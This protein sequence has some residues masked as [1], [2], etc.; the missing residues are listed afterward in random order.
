MA[1]NFRMTRRRKKHNLYL[2]LSGDF[3]GMS[4]MELIQVL[5]ENA[6]TSKKIY[7][8]T[9]GLCR[10][11]PFGQDV[12]LK[13]FAISAASSKKL[14]FKGDSGQK[15]APRGTCCIKDH[16]MPQTQN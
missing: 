2:K 16:K 15:I 14:I 4:A 8:D 13:H 5:E 11:L 7:I 6:E 9:E 12:F 10:L 1:A 3:D